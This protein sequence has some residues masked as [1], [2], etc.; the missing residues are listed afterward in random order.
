[1]FICQ[2]C[3]GDV[4]EDTNF[5]IAHFPVESPPRK[6]KTSISDTSWSIRFKRRLHIDVSGLWWALLGYAGICAFFVSQ[7]LVRMFCWILVLTNKKVRRMK[8]KIRCGLLAVLLLGSSV[9]AY[10]GN[11]IKRSEWD[12]RPEIT[13]G[14]FVYFFPVLL[15]YFM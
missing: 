14:N 5:I 9:M 1:M 4:K 2:P 8:M 12:F 3:V 10:A 6:R 13:T 11:G 7:R 15:V